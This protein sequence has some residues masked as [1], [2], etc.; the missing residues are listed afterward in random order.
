[1]KPDEMDDEERDNRCEGGTFRKIEMGRK[2][3]LGEADGRGNRQGDF[4]YTHTTHH[5]QI[6]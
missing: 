4:N 3:A 1:M 5:T 6:F 2:K